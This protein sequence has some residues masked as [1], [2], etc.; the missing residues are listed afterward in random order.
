MAADKVGGAPKSH[1]HWD[2]AKEQ[3]TKQAGIKERINSVEDQIS[4]LNQRIRDS[5]ADVNKLT[6]ENKVLL[7]RA[8]ELERAH[9][10]G[11]QVSMFARRV[12]RGLNNLFRALAGRPPVLTVS[13]IES[14]PK[15]TDTPKKLRG[16]AELRTIQIGEI[17]DRI[18]P[19]IRQWSQSLETLAAQRD[20]LS[21]TLRNHSRALL[22]EVRLA[23]KHAASERFDAAVRSM[24][25]VA[26]TGARFFGPRFQ[27][28]RA[29]VFGGLK[30]FSVS[31]AN[32]AAKNEAKAAESTASS[33]AEVEPLHE[34]L[35]H[36]IGRASVMVPVPVRSPRLT[37]EQTGLPLVD[38]RAL[39]RL[40]DPVDGREWVAMLVGLDYTAARDRTHL[41][42]EFDD[43]LKAMRLPIAHRNRG[44]VFSPRDVRRKITQMYGLDKKASAADIRYELHRRVAAGADTFMRHDEFEARLEDMGLPKD[45]NPQQIAEPVLAA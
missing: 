11:G 27:A 13:D 26:D 38:V 1:V 15:A 22:K 3:V 35:E 39:Y 16:L 10:L 42:R 4:K 7:T 9:T 21:E 6:G 36:S 20:A 44:S 18:A 2:N 28:L 32:W 33:L 5:R 12:G 25:A 23:G 29:S 43:A 14:D 41:R 31:V 34:E 37:A 24:G 8:Q 40:P 45:A 17:E 19:N 30:R